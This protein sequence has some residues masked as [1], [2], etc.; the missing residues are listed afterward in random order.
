MRK[1]RSKIRY[2]FTGTEQPETRKVMRDE[3]NFSGFLFF[4]RWLPV[5]AVVSILGCIIGE[6]DTIR[7]VGCIIEK[8]YTIR[9]TSSTI[10]WACCSQMLIN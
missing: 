8:V 4:E 9:F 7:M 10:Q 2:V 6:D 3:V 1:M 5:E